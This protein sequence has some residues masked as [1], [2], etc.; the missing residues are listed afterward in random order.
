[1]T[2]QPDPQPEPP[3]PPQSPAATDKAAHGFRNEVSWDQGKGRQ[4]D[5]NQGAEESREPN[6]GNEFE[7]G[8]QGEHAG[9]ARDQLEQVKGTPQEGTVRQSRP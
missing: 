6:L 5:S 1:M 2:R 7:A 9:V 8:D 4:P 3:M